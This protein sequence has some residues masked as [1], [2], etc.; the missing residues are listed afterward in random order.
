MFHQFT[1]LVHR[2][3]LFFIRSFAGRMTEIARKYYQPIMRFPYR[4]SCRYNVIP[5]VYGGANYS[6]F[7]PPNSYVNA[8]DFDSPKEL[9]AYLKYLSQDLR[10]YQ[11][12]LEW[13]KYYRV[14]SAT[15]RAVCTLCEVLHKQKEPKMYSTLSD[16][17]AKDK[18][19]IQTRL[20]DI[21]KYATKIT[22]ERKQN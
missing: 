17:Y 2:I 19:P 1:L 18:C 3:L 15:K 12:F 11:S 14:K 20:N 6:Q 5:V 9:V 4:Y 22:N 16:W 10:R 13:K 21:N 7:A 8:L